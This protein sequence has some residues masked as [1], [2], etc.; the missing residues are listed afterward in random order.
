MPARTV[1]VSRGGTPERLVALGA[2]LVAAFDDVLLAVSAC[3][4]HGNYP[5]TTQTPRQE[6]TYQRFTA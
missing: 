3:P 6:L 5:S 4:S 2:V 1:H